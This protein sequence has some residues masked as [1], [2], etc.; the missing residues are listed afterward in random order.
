MKKKTVQRQNGK[1]VDNYKACTPYADFRELLD[2][3]KVIE[4]AKKTDVVT[5]LIP[6]DSNGSM[7]QIMSWINSGTIGDLKEVHNWSRRPVWPHYL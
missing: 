3:E 5:H 2:K 7:D 6:W 1:S 4:M